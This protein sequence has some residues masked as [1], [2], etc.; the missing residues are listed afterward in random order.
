MFAREPLIAAARYLF[1]WAAQN[2]ITYD[3]D[4]MTLAFTARNVRKYIGIEPFGYAHYTSTGVT[5]KVRRDA[6]KSMRQLSAHRRVYLKMAVGMI[7]LGDSTYAE[8]LL[9]RFSAPFYEHIA[10]L[11][12]LEGVDLFSKYIESMPPKMR[13]VIARQIRCAS[14]WW[15]REIAQ[16]ARAA[17]KSIRAGENAK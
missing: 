1:P 14:P 3:E 2:H 15:R 7:E 5:W 12:L 4:T 11:P 8:R 10:T 16:L 13:L 17:W 9:N 6:L